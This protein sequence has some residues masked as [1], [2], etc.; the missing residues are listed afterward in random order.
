M[1]VCKLAPWP[2]LIGC[3]STH[4]RLGWP[5]NAAAAVAA[6][7]DVSSREPSSTTTTLKRPEAINRESVAA[8]RRP[9]LYAG[10]TIHVSPPVSRAG[11]WAKVRGTV[12]D[13]GK[14]IADA[15]V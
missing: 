14:I 11:W 9:S 4:T 7:C 6:T 13:M 10:T 1:P 12:G 2:Q 3:R 5:V 15:A 8:I